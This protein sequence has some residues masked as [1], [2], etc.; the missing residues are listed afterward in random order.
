MGIDDGRGRV[1]AAMSRAG[2]VSAG[3]VPQGWRMD[4]HQS[5]NNQQSTDQRIGSGEGTAHALPS[6]LKEGG[7]LF[8]TV[9]KVQ[10]FGVCDPHFSVQETS[11]FSLRGYLRS[12]NFYPKF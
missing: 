7:F 10:N 4:G 1:E 11:H 3:T 2:C 8:T 9:F 12:K 5:H 6:T